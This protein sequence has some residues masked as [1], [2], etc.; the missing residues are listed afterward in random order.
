MNKECQYCYEQFNETF[1]VP[2]MINCGHVFGKACVDYLSIYK[3]P[4]ACPLDNQRVRYNQC[5]TENTILQ[6]IADF[7]QEHLEEITGICV[8]HYKKLCES[9]KNSH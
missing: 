2:L 1:R 4:S 3:I 9:C 7:C 8:D 6:K 5:Q